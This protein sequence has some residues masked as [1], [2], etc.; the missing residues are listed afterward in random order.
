MTDSKTPI[1]YTLC[2]GAGNTILMVDG[3]RLGETKEEKI[4]RV[5][6]LLNGE[7]SEKIVADQLL[8][9]HSR[10]PLD[11]LVWNKDGSNSEMC[12]NGARAI[13]H[14]AEKRSWF[15]DIPEPNEEIKVKISGGDYRARRLEREANF[16]V[17]LGAPKYE[18]LDMVP[19]A[20]E[21]IPV[22]KVNV[23]NPHSVIICGNGENEWRVPDD[24][25]LSE[26]GPR[27]SQTLRANIEFVSVNRDAAGK[28]VPTEMRVLV[29]ELG[30]GATKSCGSGAVA[31]ATVAQKLSGESNHRNF[32]I[33]MSGGKLTVE[34]NDANE[35]ELGGPASILDEGTTHL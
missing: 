19:I 23:G 26:W 7:S 33:E 22:H 13:L 25:K 5:K 29:W 16:A 4:A 18:C 21:E 24:F 2:E 3:Y 15:S 20:G 32:A 8:E 12:G 9:V 27:L 6:A 10:D 14:L 1:P 11:F 17:N 35:A 31:V 30:S 34:F 28:E